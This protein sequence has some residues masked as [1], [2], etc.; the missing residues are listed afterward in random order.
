VINL[1]KTNIALNKKRNYTQQKHKN[2]HIQTFIHMDENLKNKDKTDTRNDNVAYYQQEL[3][4][5]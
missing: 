2:E 1:R 5:L 3:F 4:T